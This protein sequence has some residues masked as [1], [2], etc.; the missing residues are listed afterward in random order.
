MHRCSRSKAVY[1][2]SAQVFIREGTRLIKIWFR[3]GSEMRDILLGSLLQR[4][5]MGGI[6]TPRSCWRW[7]HLS[8][9]AVVTQ[10]YSLETSC[11][12]VNCFSSI[13]RHHFRGQ[14]I[15]LQVHVSQRLITTSA[16]VV[17]VFLFDTGM[18][19]FI[20]SDMHPSLHLTISFLLFVFCQ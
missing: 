8:G 11:R 7:M 5:I 20:F 17:R 16:E 9:L 1:H 10:P 6:K 19:A 14:C 12:H 15:R 4:N 3:L 18:P 2:F 13:R